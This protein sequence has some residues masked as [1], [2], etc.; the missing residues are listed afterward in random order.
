MIN[1]PKYALSFILIISNSLMCA[2]AA[3][4]EGVSY[5]SLRYSD[6]PID[7][8]VMAVEN[9]D[10]L[11]I[12]YIISHLETLNFQPPEALG[13]VDT[14]KTYWIKIDFTG[15]RDLL[16][17]D[18]MWHLE[19]VSFGEGKL[20]YWEAESGTIKAKT[21]GR[22]KAQPMNT[23]SFNR[24]NLIDGSYLMIKTRF[25]LYRG[26]FENLK[27]RYSSPSA[28]TFTREFVA[29]EKIFFQ[30]PILILLG[31]STT[32]MLYSLVVFYSSRHQ[33]FLSYALYL[34]FLTIYFVL[35][36][37]LI[38]NP[39][40]G[41]HHFLKFFV[42]E[43]SQIAM[44]LCYVMF[45][46]NFLNTKTYYYGLHR[47]I[48]VV[49]VALLGFMVVDAIVLFSNALIPIQ[50]ELMN[51][52]R[53]LILLF[54]FGAMIYLL[55]NAHNRLTYF[56]VIG[57]FSFTS[58]ALL[59]WI[60]VEIHYMVYGAA[61]E[62]FIFAMGLG[63]KI[64]RMNQDKLKVER[65]VVQ[66]KMSALRAQMNPHFIFNSL[67]SIQSFIVTNDRP[68]ALKYLAKFSSLLREVLDS[69]IDIN[70]ILEKEI[71]L[72][73]L[74]LDLE[75][76]RFDGGFCH[77]IEVDPVLDIYNLEVPLLLIQPYVENAVIHGLAQ[78]NSGQKELKMTFQDDKDFICCTIIDTGIGRKAAN[79]LKQKKG[80]YRPSRGMS[81]TA[82]RLSLLTSG[83][84]M[85]TLVDV[86]DL[87][88]TDGEP[89]GTRVTIK[90]PKILNN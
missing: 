14:R 7:T 33:E 57:S 10:S 28:I 79:E 78:K 13:R 26:K 77:K 8:K 75:T 17:S 6:I 82:Q 32:L 34:L 60:T 53:V 3:M 30:L 61:L 70:V 59:T 44:H 27:F 72:L 41:E 19:P 69:S 23:I 56:V 29:K 55:I 20:F 54:A 68:R 38:A 15:Q 58:G 1:H 64:K 73:Q 65:E 88:G 85:G 37:P 45:V 40:F 63:Y 51:G 62:S 31:L 18:H 16:T 90:I 71:R 80:I 9:G 74:Y 87:Y 89:T 36:S 48:Q 4:Q 84:Y 42:H 39:L 2:F 5:D 66:T 76:L 35:K 50:R 24:S 12:A 81:V 22:F 52:E 46:M 83:E 47:A 43:E 21:I 25:I 11:D 67:S 49:I 86:E